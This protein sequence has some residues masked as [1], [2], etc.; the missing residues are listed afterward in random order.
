MSTRSTRHRVRSSQGKA[1][2]CDGM[3]QLNVHATGVDI[4]AHEIMA[5]VPNGDEQQK[6]LSQLALV[7]ILFDPRSETLSL[8]QRNLTNRDEE[9]G[10]I[11]L[12][13]DTL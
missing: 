5:G 12:K 11:R 13:R 10:G 8:I 2:P 4:G 9:T 7:S 6:G 3:R 1:R